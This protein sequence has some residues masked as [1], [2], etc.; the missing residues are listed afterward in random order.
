M[1]AGK[2]TFIKSLAAVLGIKD[3]VASPTYGIVNEY[4]DGDGES[5]YH[6]DFY[7]INDESEAE[8]I[9][10]VEYFD[11]GKYCFIE[12]PQKV[13]RLLPGQYVTVNI[14]AASPTTRRLEMRMYE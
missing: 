8:D 10:A 12:W 5:Y 4:V 14:Q 7:R 9:G 2:T 3:T 13:E 1:G 6:F 11:S